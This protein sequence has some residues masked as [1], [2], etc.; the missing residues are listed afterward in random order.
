M[1]DF[2]TGMLPTKTRKIKNGTRKKNVISICS[3]NLTLTL[4]CRTAYLVKTQNKSIRARN[5]TKTK[6]KSGLFTL[7]KLGKCS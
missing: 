1:L 6:N 3:L 5:K 2:P 4:Y 7:L